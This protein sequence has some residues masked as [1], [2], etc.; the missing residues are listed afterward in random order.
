MP[1]PTTAADLARLATLLDETRAIR[2]ILLGDLIHARSGRQPETL[3][4]FTRWRGARPGLSIT[5][6]RGNHDRSAGDPPPEWGIDT[7]SGP[8]LLEPF[9]L[10]HEPTDDPR[11]H[12][13]AGHIH[14]AARLHG[15]AGTSLRAP[16]FWVGP[17]TT[18]LPAFGSFT[19]AKVI[20]PRA[21]D[22]VFVVGDDQVIEANLV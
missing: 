12:V 3:D 6:V 20:H 11:G 17:R 1:E 7:I 14:P 2:L 4:S 19:G 18:I 13:L 8:A 10:A 16:C 21:G 22:R 15:A 9:V 5:L